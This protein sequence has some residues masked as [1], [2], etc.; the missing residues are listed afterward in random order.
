MFGGST[1]SPPCPGDSPSADRLP[2][3]QMERDGLTLHQWRW[4]RRWPNSAESRS[5]DGEN[6]ALQVCSVQLSSGILGQGGWMVPMALVAHQEMEAGCLALLFC[7]GWVTAA[8]AVPWEQ[9]HPLNVLCKGSEDTERLFKED[10]DIQ[11][12][13]LHPLIETRGIKVVLC[14]PSARTCSTRHS[15]KGRGIQPPVFRSSLSCWNM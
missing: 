10:R 9:P 1:R 13:L 8:A 5:S 2:T 4:W 11:M 6:E 3:G 12:P 7:G 15:L 14:P